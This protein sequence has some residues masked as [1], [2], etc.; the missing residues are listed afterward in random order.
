MKKLENLKR[1]TPQK[2]S[3][4]F[5]EC[6]FLDLV[7]KNFLYFLTFYETKAPKMFFIFQETETLI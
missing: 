2:N 3:L 7:L 6:N 5:G 4:Y 1:S